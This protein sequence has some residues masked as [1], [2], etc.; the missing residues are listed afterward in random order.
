MVLIALAAASLLE[1][2]KFRANVVFLL[3]SVRR[4]WLRLALT[5]SAGRNPL[6]SG[7]GL[8]L[9]AMPALAPCYLLCGKFEICERDGEA[10]LAKRKKH[11]NPE[12][13]RL[14]GLWNRA[15]RGD[16]ES[17]DKLLNS[18]LSHPS[19]DAFVQA[20]SLMT[21]TSITE[22]RL[23]EQDKQRLYERRERWKKS[24]VVSAPRLRAAAAPTLPK[25]AISAVSGGLPSLGTRSR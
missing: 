18:L 5:R 6:L 4:G 20:W 10:R 17:K 13:I 24:A 2:A 23:S 3:A 25:D 22:N 19:I 11:Q 15:R 16:L 9:T 1:I 8:Y 7:S 21:V 14:E 12:A